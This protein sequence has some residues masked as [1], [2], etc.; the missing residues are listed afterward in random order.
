MQ[1]GFNILF[2]DL[3]NLY[4]LEKLDK[5]FCAFL[6]KN[7][8]EIYQ[9]LKKARAGEV[10]DESELIIEIAPYLEE[11]IIT[12]LFLLAKELKTI[13]KK[14]T[15]LDNFFKAKR[16]F[17]QRKVAKKYQLAE[18]KLFD[19]K[20]ISKKIAVILGDYYFSEEVFA[21]YIC[22]KLDEK[23]DIA[24]EF[25]QYSAYQIFIDEKQSY[26]FQI[27]KK[28]QEIVE[29][30]E[31]K[32]N[33]IKAKLKNIKKREGFSLTEEA[34]DLKKS[35]SEANY[36]IICH[37]Q[38]KD[39]CSKG[40]FDKEKKFKISEE[41]IELSGCPLEEKISEMNF[42][43]SKGYV[44]GGLATAMI[45]N[46]LL[47]LTGKRICNDCTQSCIYQ[48]QEAVDIPAIESQV[49]DEILS[50]NYGFEIYSLLTRWNPLN[51]KRFLPRKNSNYKI[52]IVGTGPS[53][54]NL[55]H[56]LLQEG[57]IVVAID[58]LKIEPSKHFFQ[59]IKNIKKDFFENLD[60]RK[61][62]GFGGVAEYGITVRWNKNYLNVIRLILE[63]NVNFR[64][65]G[66]V[67]F[68][69]QINK[70]I[71][72]K[73]LGFDHIA[74][75]AG[76]G[77]PTIIP[78]KNNLSKGVRKA[79][80][81]LMNLQAGGAFRENS[82]SNLQIRMPVIVIGGGL[83]AID[84]ATEALAYY[85]RQIKKFAKLYQD[86][87][88]KYGKIEVEKEWQKEDREIA[89][90]FLAH[91]RQLEQ[92]NQKKE[93]NILALMNKWGGVKILYRKSLEESPAYRLNKEEV[94]KA[95]AEGIQFYENITP[96]EVK[97][98]K[99]SSAEFLSVKS[100]LQESSL[101]FRARMI[102]V[103]AGTKPNVI[104]A[105]EDED[106]KEDYYFKAINNKGKII[107]LTTKKNNIFVY[108]S[109]DKKAISFFGDMHPSYSGNVVKAMASAKNG[110]PL[111]T[112][113][114]KNI[115]SQDN[116]EEFF[117][118][119]EKNL[120]AEIVEIKRLT[121]TI[122][123]IIILA[124][125]AS[126]KF[127]P[128]QFYKLQ[129]YEINAKKKD[130]YILAMENIALTG[131][132]VDKEKGTISLIALEMGGSSNLCKNLKKGE[133]VMLM[134][135]TGEA[136]KIYKNKNIML[137][138]GGLGNA[139][140][141]SIGQAFKQA[142]SKVLYFAGYKQN[143]DRYKIEE[144]E[145]ASDII[146]WACDEKSDISITRKQD[147]VFDGNIIDAIESYG[148]KKN[149]D[150]KL[151]EIDHIIAI[152]SDGMMKAMQN[153]KNN[154]LKEYFKQKNP[155]AIASINSPMQCMMKEICASCLQ[156]HIDDDGNEYF[157]YS[158][159]NQDQNMD[160]VDFSHLR[161]RLSQNSLSEKL[162]KLKLFD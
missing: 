104:L 2:Q 153:A 152:G 4:S 99:Y 19:I 155:T 108:F 75:C 154:I 116:K 73:E 60:K 16:L 159:F 8:Q 80:D 125:L 83:T 52:L 82:L 20:E 135:P 151:E 28:N 55:A 36:C 109:K 122:I 39:S 112:Q 61:A 157:V 150:I 90:E 17:V 130:D 5:I 96:S 38:N 115:N 94:Q 129:N 37:K 21:D 31:K 54:I 9:K 85:P 27:P 69:S 44:L 47:A 161:N 93:P 117:R 86:L 137:V 35:L 10:E 26:L 97:L 15:N 43:R 126:K 100:L 78:I 13:R 22:Q 113:T 144:I 101:H 158:C 156:K 70:E 42:L 62:D 11:F 7:N 66:G 32:D 138:G 89:E 64:L 50:I 106:I 58:G 25:Y 103:A 68:G 87:V 45:D 105:K 114:L 67:R 23:Q 148:R 14:T 123:E 56:H 95:F 133:Q 12:K 65:F 72:F 139:V 74:L 120:L 147:R 53:G 34:P 1:L 143:I 124:P 79:S 121:P 63:R 51:L 142:G 119:L 162:V 160:K 49:L 136:T 57:H 107:E 41:N 33:V 71:A 149:N 84:T 110:Y 146:V 140:L 30:F 91:Y 59:P 48:K 118:N 18:I 128:G 81:F 77:S 141:F 92:E 132:S 98:D 131:A 6:L 40:L 3:Y 29:N 46:P 134:G 24:E 102:L 76:A 145:K 111:I 88:K 127:L